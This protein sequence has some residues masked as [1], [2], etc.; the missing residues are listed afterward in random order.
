MVAVDIKMDS[1]YILK[2]ELVYI[3]YDL[4]VEKKKVQ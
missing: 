1:N 4:V 3:F 2:V